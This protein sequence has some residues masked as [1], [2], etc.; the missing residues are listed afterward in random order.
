MSGSPKG[1]TP[2]S[3]S[4]TTSPSKIPPSPI[5]RDVETGSGEYIEGNIEGVVEDHDQHVV[6]TIGES[7]DP[8]L[9]LPYGDLRSLLEETAEAASR[10]VLEEFVSVHGVY[11]GTD[12]NVVAQPAPSESVD[13]P[14]RTSSASKRRGVVE[15]GQTGAGKRPAN[16]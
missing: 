4:R 3:N 1:A 16:R 9:T 14:T 11:V 12:V 7:I 6:S 10:R 5:A 13:V 15:E 8:M 2:A